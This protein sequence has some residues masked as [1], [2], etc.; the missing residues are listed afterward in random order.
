MLRSGILRADHTSREAGS[1]ETHQEVL[2]IQANAAVCDMISILLRFFLVIN[3]A[4]TQY[5]EL[6]LQFPS[7]SSDDRSSRRL[8]RERLNFLMLTSSFRICSNAGMVNHTFIYEK[9]YRGSA[10][11]NPASIRRS[12]GCSVNAA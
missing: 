9:P 12:G 3:I 8:P 2:L 7:A 6:I 5:C 10:A 4:V 1:A 11:A